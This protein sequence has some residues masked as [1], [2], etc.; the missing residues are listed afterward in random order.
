MEREELLT[1]AGFIR[2]LARSLV[3]DEHRAADIEQNTWLAALE[4]PPESDRSIRAWFSRVIRNM[5]VSTHRG[6]TR[7]A[8]YENALES[9]V[10][11]TSPEEIAMRKEALRHLTQAVLHLDEP[12]LS[13]IILRYYENLPARE[14][15]RRLGVPHE[16]VKT[17]IQRGL[18][19]L[20]TKLDSRYEGDRK[21]WCL[22]LAPLAGLKLAVPAAA[23]AGT[24]A[25]ASSAS[26]A[27]ASAEIPGS[28][29]LSAKLKVVLAAAVLFI[30]TSVI[31]F[32]V[33][34]DHKTPAGSTESTP[35]LTSELSESKTGGSGEKI[36]STDSVDQA[37]NDDTSDRIVLSPTGLFISGTVID[38][39]T[40]K[41]IEAYDFRLTTYVDGEGWTQPIHETVRDPEGQFHFPL[42]KSGRYNLTIWSSRHTKER[43]NGLDISET[44]SSSDLKIELDS[45]LRVAGRVVDD[46]TGEPIAGAIVGP[47]PYPWKTDLP[48]L[49]Y[50]DFSE[51]C[52]H[53][54]TGADGSFS[55]RGLRDFE[56]KIAAVHHD[57]A[58]GYAST[59]PGSG[60]KIEIRLKKG[61]RIFGRALDDAGQPAEGL[62]IRMYGDRIPLARP[63]MTDADGRFVTE[64]IL[65]GRVVLK[66]GDP[67]I[68]LRRDF[69]FSE[70]H[71]VVYVVDGDLEVNFGP[72]PGQVTWRGTLYGHDGNPVAG[73]KLF[74]RHAKFSYGETY[75]Y[76]L[77]R[78]VRCDSEGRFE[79]T[80]LHR[81]RY[82]VTLEI[83][84]QIEWG[85]IPFETAGLVE[86]DINLSLVSSLS[87]VVINEATGSPFT[88]R[89]GTVRAYSHQT[90]SRNSLEADIDKEGRFEIKGVLPG[91]YYLSAHVGNAVSDRIKGIK[92]VKGQEV[93]DLIIPVAPAGSLTISL[94]GFEN[95]S[96]AYFS[97]SFSEEASG[98]RTYMGRYSVAKTIAKNNSFTLD[99]GR[100]TVALSFGGMG[101]TQRAFDV[102]PDQR[103]EIR[104]RRDSIESCDEFIS[105]TGTVFKPNG[106]PEGDILLRFSATSVPQL[107]EENKYLR[108][109]TDSA[110]HYRLEGFKPGRWQVSAE[111]AMGGRAYFPELWIPPDAD[112]PLV[113]D[114]DLPVSMVSG[115]LY[116]EL[117]GIPITKNHPRTW[118]ASLHDVKRDGIVSR[119]QG[120]D[121]SNRFRLA[122]LSEGD[123]ELTVNAEGYYHYKSGAFR[124]V[125]GQDL[126]MGDIQLTPC[127]L[128]D[129]EVL[130][131][132]L[133]PIERIEVTCDGTRIHSENTI[134][135]KRRYD[136]LPT[137]TVTITVGARGHY[138]KAITVKLLPG[139]PVE[140]RIVL[141][142]E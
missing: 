21:A 91:S 129:L 74:L 87:G 104:I 19:Q 58:E 118:E 142:P 108:A 79:V 103:T 10:A 131:E 34:P 133:V 76:R 43:V 18:D 110:G 30:G 95:D 85:K 31:L 44:K 3:R 106:M 120:T 99:Q 141:Q 57:F 138:E 51:V 33:L 9:P 28:L 128:L 48:S 46:A 55:L 20:R 59:T 17:R 53:H 6:E 121:G 130:D 134:Q 14:V 119:Y 2:S 89:K 47:A 8:K 135:G 84:D 83:P 88:D 93:R 65:P 113:F 77:T 11:V 80:K 24:A 36:T 61:Y 92:V 16:T 22:A 15:A 49:Y 62:L 5:I 86:K 63:A 66:A 60:E 7:R 122:C 23:A 102:L 29:L 124:V 111:L 67:P 45:G 13:A 126:Y 137:G 71:K 37:T 70:E 68:E 73:G 40:R 140:Q 42:A 117:N 112:D 41:P 81:G 115:S 72:D 32:Q 35:T 1:H 132:S 50:L 69:D 127:G 64:P 26:S 97:L 101:Y 100:W 109:R 39:S 25:A 4:H 125:E 116:D 82:R 56:K 114:L 105:L 27:A 12:Y 96:D 107:P 136:K 52:I 78:D 94:E 139:R 90:G 54:R 75:W 38:S 123:F 98:Q